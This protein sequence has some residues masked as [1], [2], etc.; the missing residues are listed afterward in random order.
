MPDLTLESLASRLATVEKELAE[1]KSGKPKENSWQNLVGMFTGDEFTQT[2]IEETEAIR[3]ADRQAA[4]EGNT[5][6]TE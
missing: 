4:R 5:E 1:L 6:V 3:N 2:W